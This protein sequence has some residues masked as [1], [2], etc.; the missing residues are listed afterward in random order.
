LATA[1]VAQADTGEVLAGTGD[2]GGGNLSYVGM[3]MAPFADLWSG[4]IATSFSTEAIGSFSISAESFLFPYVGF[5]TGP[6]AGQPDA[7]NSSWGFNGRRHRP[8]SVPKKQ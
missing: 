5:F 3:G 4:A 7:I 1:F 8:L 2:V 6:K